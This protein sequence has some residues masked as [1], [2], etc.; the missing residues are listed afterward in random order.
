MCVFCV[1]WCFAD[2]LSLPSF[3]GLGEGFVDVC[4]FLYVFAVVVGGRVFMFCSLF[5]CLFLLFLFVFF[6]FCLCLFVLWFV[7]GSS[8]LFSACCISVSG[9]SLFS[10]LK[11][12]HLA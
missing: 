8:S 1:C 11:S 7:F 9:K 2:L 3:F 12:G 10:L 6:L 4:G 5:V